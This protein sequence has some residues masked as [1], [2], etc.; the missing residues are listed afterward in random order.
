MWFRIIIPSMKQKIIFHLSE[1]IPNSIDV[2][3]FSTWSFASVWANLW[4]YWLF[5]DWEAQHK[6][7]QIL[8][9]I[10]VCIFWRSG[11]NFP[12]LFLCVLS[13]W[14]DTGDPSLKKKPTQNNTKKTEVIPLHWFHLFDI[15]AINW[16]DA[17]T[18]CS[19]LPTAAAEESGRVRAQWDSL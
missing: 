14:L 1:F 18:K 15:S 7:E 6:S 19:F 10:N 3:T 17:E 9:G 4:W 2:R 13:D 11:E 16:T 8:K 5:L 12:C